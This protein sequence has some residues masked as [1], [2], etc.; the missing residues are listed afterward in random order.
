MWNRAKE[1]FSK[2]VIRFDAVFDQVSD[3]YTRYSSFIK[4]LL[5]SSVIFSSVHWL[6]FQ[7]NVYMNQEIFDLNNIPSGY[8]V[9][10]YPKDKT[11]SSVLPDSLK[12]DLCITDTLVRKNYNVDIW[13]VA[14]YTSRDQIVKIEVPDYAINQFKLGEQF[15]NPTQR[16]DKKEKNE[17]KL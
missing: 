9:W 16:E 6:D 1:I 12:T 11:Q 17:P 4:L 7:R 10:L 5:I 13:I 2:Y 8:V 15:I 14:I 3:F